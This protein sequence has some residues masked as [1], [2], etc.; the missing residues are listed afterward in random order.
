MI[1]SIRNREE[2]IDYVSHG[3]PVK[4]VL[5]WG[6][7]KSETRITKTCF[8]QWYDSPFTQKG[9]AYLTAEHFMM[10]EKARLF[11][12]SNAEQKILLADNPGEAKKLGREVQG[13]ENSVWEHHRFDI[14]VKAN[15]LKFGQNAE[16]KEFLLN[17]GDRILV[18]ASPVDKIWGVGLA[19]DHPAVENPY[20]WR[21]LNLL[22]FALMEV[23]LQ[24]SA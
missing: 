3:N 6:H 8:S 17:T 24:L 20:Q 19:M 2:L 12:D 5:F 15:L 13:F 9:I 10:A 4:Y 21:G 11:G 16:L 22:G 23:R 7:Q 1:P 14:V 18:E